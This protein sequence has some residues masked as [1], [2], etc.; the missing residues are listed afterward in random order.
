MAYVGYHSLD[1]FSRSLPARPTLYEL[2]GKAVEDCAVRYPEG[3][4]KIFAPRVLYIMTNTLL[5][6][7][8]TPPTIYVF[9]PS[10]NKAMCQ[11][12]R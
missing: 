3:P 8:K 7:S 1:L 10:S 6:M 11:R 12:I 4:L 9:I 2:E 5:T